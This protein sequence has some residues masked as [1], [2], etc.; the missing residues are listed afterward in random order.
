MKTLKQVQ[1]VVVSFAVALVTLVTPT[2][3]A[4]RGVPVTNVQE[5]SIR[6]ATVKTVEENKGILL[7]N[8]ESKFLLC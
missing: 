6:V 3:A 5:T 4:P 1:A 7:A 2:N 8:P